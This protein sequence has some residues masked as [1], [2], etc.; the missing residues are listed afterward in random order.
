MPECLACRAKVKSKTKTWAEGDKFVWVTAFNYILLDLVCRVTIH[1]ESK[2]KKKKIQYLEARQMR[3]DNRI[4][5]VQRA[6]SRSKKQ[7]EN[8]TEIWIEKD[9][10]F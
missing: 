2:M 10:W 7:S 8:E 1:A 4:L 5:F 3:A 6:R 9:R